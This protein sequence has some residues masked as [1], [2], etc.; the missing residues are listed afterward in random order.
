V[1]CSQGISLTVIKLRFGGGGAYWTNG[2]FGSGTN[3]YPSRQF[4]A[5]IADLAAI[6]GQSG[7]RS[8]L[9]EEDGS[10]NLQMVWDG[11]R[12]EGRDE[13]SLDEDFPSV[14]FL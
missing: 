7:F 10:A 6:L 4:S 5:K 12:N 9:L 1:S 14:Y 2:Q 13:F 8:E 3:T 11:G